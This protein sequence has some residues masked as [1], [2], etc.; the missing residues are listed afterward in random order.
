M[1]MAMATAMAM[2]M[3]IVMATARQPDSQPASQPEPKPSFAV[4]VRVTPSHPFGSIF[5][6]VGGKWL[7]KRVFEICGS[8]ML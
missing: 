5:C 1:A 2:A 8:A 6:A 3:A 4:A 7:A